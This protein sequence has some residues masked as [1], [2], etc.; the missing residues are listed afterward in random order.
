MNRFQ[1]VRAGSTEEAV[2][3]LEEDFDRVK[4]LAGGL[5]L[6]GE[7]KAN[8]LEPETVVSISALR[9]LQEIED[10]GDTVRIGAGVTLCDISHHELIRDRYTALAEAAAAVGSPQIRHA[11]TLGGNLCQRPRCW[12]YRDEFYDCL[13]KGGNQCFSIMGRNRY[14][15]ILGGGP[16]FI[17]HPSD[18]APALV[19]L[20]ASVGLLGPD[21]TKEIPVNEFFVSPSQNLLRESVL[22]ADE[23]VTHVSIPNQGWK[24]TYLKFREKES[25]DWALSSVAVALKRN[26]NV[27][28]EARVVLGGVAPIPWRSEQAEKVLQ[29]KE[30][31]QSLAEQAGKVAVEGAFALKDNEGKIPLT[32]TLVKRAVLRIEEE[33]SAVEQSWVY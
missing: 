6:L 22:K 18:C 2:S 1:Y 29:G 32:E 24:S 21:G 12:Y 19:A 3:F 13:K 5:D 28:E 27:C 9:E 33:P 17:V 14:H 7:L 25:F 8:I 4:I 16:C 31:T 11:G 20:G 30:I 26:G 10:R 15:A 23:I